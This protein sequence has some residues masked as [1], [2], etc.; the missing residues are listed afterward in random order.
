MT[1]EYDAYVGDVGIEI[2]LD[3][4]AD[5]SGASALKIKYTRPNGDANDWDAGEKTA[6]SLCYV[7]KAGDLNNAGIW[8]LQA[9]AETAGWKLHGKVVEFH[10][11]GILT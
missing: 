3:V 1:E 7:T 8:K 9:Y 4:G 11:G 5:I 2:V 10:V 6:T